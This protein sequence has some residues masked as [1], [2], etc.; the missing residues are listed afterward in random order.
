MAFMYIENFEF[1]KIP[2]LWEIFSK[3]SQKSNNMK[4][5]IEICQNMTPQMY[6]ISRK[7]WDIDPLL[8]NE[9]LKI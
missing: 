1:L 5:F 6:Q 9:Y 7:I 3:I 2:F 4:K 8:K